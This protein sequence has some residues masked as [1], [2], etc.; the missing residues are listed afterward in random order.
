MSDLELSDMLKNMEEAIK[1]SLN[2]SKRKENYENSN[3]YNSWNNAFKEVLEFMN[4][5]IGE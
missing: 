5:H 4:K 3:T 2:F 1:L